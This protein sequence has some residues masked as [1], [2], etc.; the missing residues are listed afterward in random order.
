MPRTLTEAAGRIGAIVA[1]LGLAACAGGSG[2]PDTAQSAT[3]DNGFL[4]G[5]YLDKDTDGGITPAE[6][7]EGFKAADTNGDGQLSQGEFQAGGG[8]WGGGGGRGGR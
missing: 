7:S 6:W 5:T 1:C 3:C 2:N 4:C 8:N